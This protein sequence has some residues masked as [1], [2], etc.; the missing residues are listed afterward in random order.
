M[1]ALT[2]H[3]SSLDIEFQAFFLRKARS[4]EL[5]DPSVL[6]LKNAV[7]LQALLWK[8][9]LHKDA[10]TLQTLWENPMLAK[11]EPSKN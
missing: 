11:Q 1:T 7:T 6:Y 5:L 2:S 3:V 9:L 8:K 10:N 4:V